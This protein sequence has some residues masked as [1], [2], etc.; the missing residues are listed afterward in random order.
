V[1]GICFIL[2]GREPKG[3]YLVPQA[4]TRMIL[5][6]RDERV[7]VLRLDGEL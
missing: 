1:R 4:L 6:E 7:H 5:K 3:S 2:N